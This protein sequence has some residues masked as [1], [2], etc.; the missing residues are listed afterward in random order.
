MQH[1][2][3]PL[4]YHLD[5]SI[6]MSEVFNLQSIDELHQPELTFPHVISFF[7]AQQTLH[8]TERP[9]RRNAIYIDTVNSSDGAH[10]VKYDK[11]MFERH[12]CQ[13]WSYSVIASSQHGRPSA[14]RDFR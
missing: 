2:G 12:V 6:E 13:K 14:L 10:H 8:Q 11:F 3:N 7:V 4:L 9:S 5:L 1:F